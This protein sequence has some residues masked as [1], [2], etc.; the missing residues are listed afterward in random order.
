MAGTPHRDVHELLAKDIR[1]PQ[2]GL[3]KGRA[4]AMVKAVTTTEGTDLTRL[5]LGGRMTQCRLPAS[6]G[7]P[8]LF[9]HLNSWR[10]E[11]SRSCKANNGNFGFFLIFSISVWTHRILI[12][13]KATK[14][15]VD[16]Y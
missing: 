15:I 3:N 13:L 8:F 9:G 12:F 4:K 11:D 16:L 1:S 7:S 10:K 6:S 14:S 5:D 2:Q